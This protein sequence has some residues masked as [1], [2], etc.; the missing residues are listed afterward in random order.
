M[1]IT[2]NIDNQERTFIAPFISTRKLRKAMALVKDLNGD[3][4]EETMDKLAEYLIEV[5]GNQF[6]LDQLYDGFPG[7]KFFKK[8]IDDITSITGEFEEKIKN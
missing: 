8:A 3:F 2:L 5:Y 6:T 7:N 4:N 1:Q